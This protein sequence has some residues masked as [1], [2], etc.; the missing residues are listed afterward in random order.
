M[1]RTSVSLDKDSSDALHYPRDITVDRL[2]KVGSPKRN[3]VGSASGESLCLLGGI[4]MSEKRVLPLNNP[5]SQKSAT[6]A[7]DISTVAAKRVEGVRQGGEGELKVIYMLLRCR[8][9]LKEQQIVFAYWKPP[10][11][12]R[13]IGCGDLQPTQGYAMIAHA[14]FPLG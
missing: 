1:I 4:T 13:C 5:I 14:N 8:G 9:C 10:K 12:H 6:K 11:W 2:H 7:A 3:F